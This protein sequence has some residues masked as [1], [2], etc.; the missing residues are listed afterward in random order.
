MPQS[1]IKLAKASDL[2]E[3]RSMALLTLDFLDLNSDLFGEDKMLGW[4]NL[5]LL[6]FSVPS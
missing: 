3:A 2:A 5:R 4:F 1:S 6:S